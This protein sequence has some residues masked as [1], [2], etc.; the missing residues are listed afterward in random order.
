MGMSK[1]F[2]TLGLLSALSGVVHS[3]EIRVLTAGAYK[4]VAIALAPEFEKQ[5]GH[6]LIIDNGTAG[7]LQKRVAQGE[8]FDL[9]VITPPVIS[10][11]DKDGWVSGSGTNLAKVGIAV[12]IKA[13]ADKPDLS[14]VPGVVLAGP[15][16]DE[17]QSWTI[18]SAAIS[19][20][21]AQPQAAR[22]LLNYLGSPEARAVLAAKGMVAP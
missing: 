8:A 16:P 7:G 2:V 19:A 22:E 15:L 21:A 20:K 11:L 13:G 10:A 18:Y 17:I 9:A 4:A 14:S 5:T 3:A 6:K 12:G 1:F